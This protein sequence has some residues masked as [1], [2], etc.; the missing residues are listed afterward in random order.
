[1]CECAKVVTDESGPCLSHVGR[2]SCGGRHCL[3]GSRANDAI[4]A[5]NS[6]TSDGAV[7]VVCEY[8]HVAMSTEASKG[9]NR[10]SVGVACLTLASLADGA[11]SGTSCSVLDPE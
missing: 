10:L 1:M 7:V 4:E 8:G 2:L 11:T 3:A 5:G 6:M 9:E